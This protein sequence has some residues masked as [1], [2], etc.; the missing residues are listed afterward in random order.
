MTVS[1][2]A[3]SSRD[4][5]P[6]RVL[7]VCGTGVATSTVV[8]ARVREHLSARPDSARFTISQGKVADLLGGR[9]EADVVVATTGVPAGVSIPV[10]PAVPLLTG[11]GADAVYAQLDQTIDQ[12]DSAA[13]T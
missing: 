12:I 9:G 7:I 4:A 10:V 2:D 5:A 1:N 3:T 8:A 6:V 13:T 11:L